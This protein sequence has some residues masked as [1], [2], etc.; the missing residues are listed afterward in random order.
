RRRSRW[1]S[2]RW[3]GQQ[4]VIGQ[5]LPGQGPCSGSWSPAQPVAID[6]VSWLAAG[7]RSVSTRA[8][9]LQSFMVAGAAGGHRS[10]ELA[11]CR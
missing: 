2:I 5:G 1:P 9:P 6:P 3:A 11:S 8:G 7:D 4:L 10:G